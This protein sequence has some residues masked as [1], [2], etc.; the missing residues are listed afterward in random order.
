[1]S[2][3]TSVRGLRGMYGWRDVAFVCS[4][5]AFRPLGV[6]EGAL[7]HGYVGVVVRVG[8]GYGAL[9]AAQA[10]GLALLRPTEPIK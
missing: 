1:M 9:G 8:E 2:A 4:N 6:G 10:T 5:V 7:Y 3:V